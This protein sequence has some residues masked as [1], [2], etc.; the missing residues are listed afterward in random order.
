M[1]FLHRMQSLPSHWWL[2]GV[3]KRELGYWDIHLIILVGYFCHL[4]QAP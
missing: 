4:R 1:V 3:Y 2:L